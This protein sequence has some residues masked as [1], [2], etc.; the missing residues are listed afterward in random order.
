MRQIGAI[1]EKIVAIVNSSS[2][3]VEK[4]EDLG[5]AAK[6]SPSDLQKFRQ[7][8]RIS[9]NEIT[10]LLLENDSVKGKLDSAREAKK[11]LVSFATQFLSRIDSALKLLEDLL[12]D[13]KRK[14]MIRV[15]PVCASP[16]SPLQRN[17]TLSRVS[18]PKSPTLSG[19]LKFLL[20]D[21]KNDD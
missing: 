19:G 7:R 10:Q 16:L 2:E 1:R 11:E 15:A 14:E 20:N 21:M 17:H 4:F 13:E 6:I 18:I 8:F 3:D 12:N 5:T 9:D